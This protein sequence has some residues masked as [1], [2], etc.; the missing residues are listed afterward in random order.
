MVLVLKRKISVSKLME[1]KVWTSPESSNGKRGKSFAEGRPGRGSLHRVAGADHV[2]SEGACEPA[3]RPRRSRWG[4]K[5]GLQGGF[6]SG[7]AGCLICGLMR[8]PAREVTAPVARTT[9]TSKCQES[10]WHPRATAVS[11]EYR[12]PPG[13]TKSV[14]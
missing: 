1:V 12:R 2:A 5:Q 4:V 9:A 14:H 8:G 13:Y 10:A 3:C 11:A 6:E 7:K